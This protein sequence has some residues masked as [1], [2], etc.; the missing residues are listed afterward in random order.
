MTKQEMHEVVSD[1]IAAGIDSAGVDPA[2]AVHA[3]H[4]NPSGERF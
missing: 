4:G 3:T 1:T 2:R